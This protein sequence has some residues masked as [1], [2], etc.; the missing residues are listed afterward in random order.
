MAREFVFLANFV[1]FMLVFLEKYKFVCLLKEILN[2][3]IKTTTILVISFKTSPKLVFH[4][5]C[6]FY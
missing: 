3:I 5:I 4:S 1:I 6:I 2:C